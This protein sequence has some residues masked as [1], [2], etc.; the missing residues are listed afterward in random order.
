MEAR[1]EPLPQL[2]TL[3]P[4]PAQTRNGRI[5]EHEPRTPQ[6]TQLTGQS[7]AGGG[8]Q[9]AWGREAFP[10]GRRL[11]RAPSLPG[12]RS[13][14]WPKLPGGSFGG[15]KGHS[16]EFWDCKGFRPTVMGSLVK[17]G[18]VR[19]LCPVYDPGQP[20]PSC[21]AMT[22][23]SHVRVY[24]PF[25]CGRFRSSGVRQGIPWASG[26]ST[27]P[28]PDSCG[29]FPWLCAGRPACLPGSAIEVQVPCDCGL[30]RGE[31]DGDLWRSGGT[32]PC[33]TVS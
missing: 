16:L 5:G 14:R 21:A 13:R 20:C 6:P 15:E 24:A 12:Q 1:A 22:R 19:A 29:A 33:H 27:E 32:G 31:V 30:G 3:A 18:E 7:G 10:R 9:P 2:G 11:G 26:R 23:S 25:R 4:P 28:V 8:G 17:E